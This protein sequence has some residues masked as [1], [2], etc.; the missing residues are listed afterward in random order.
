MDTFSFNIDGDKVCEV[1]DKCELEFWQVHHA[2]DCWN[3]I[4]KHQNKDDWF[5]I[6]HDATLK[7]RSYWAIF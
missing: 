3:V 7:W 2:Y 6:Y 5:A 4:S 1:L